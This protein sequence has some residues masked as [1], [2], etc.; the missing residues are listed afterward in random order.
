MCPGLAGKK[1]FVA[2]ASGFI[3]SRL[4][5][6]LTRA[7]GAEVHAL[8][9]RVGTVG[10]ARLARLSGVR[11][12]YGDVR[13]GRRVEEAGRGCSYFVYCVTGSPG[14]SRRQKAEELTGTANVLS[15]A[16]REG[17]ER[18]VYFSSAAVHDP[19]RSGEE[20][21]EESPRNGK[22]LAWRKILGE[23]L[24]AEHRRREGTPTVVLRPTCVW[25][26]WSP[27]WTAAAAALIRKGV[28]FLRSAGGGTANPIYIDNL[29][30]AV[31]LAFTK[32]EAVGEAFLINDDEPRTWGELYGGYA[33]FL[34]VPLRSLP[35]ATGTLEGLR[36]SL[37]NARQ[38]L[39]GT[40]SG[41]AGSG[42]DVLRQLYDH[43]P[44]VR[45]GVSL[46]PERIQW[47][48]RAYAARR[49]GAEKGPLPSADFLPADP[50]SRPMRE[51]YRAKARYSNAKAKR[52]LG[53]RPRVSFQAALDVTCQWL[54]YAGYR[55][56]G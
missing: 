4:A 54:E 40:L 27:T 7:Y 47:L 35:E 25:G 3:G 6:C 49:G 34:G 33:R 23:A 37:H 56:P 46:L 17:A 14:S 2:G 48:L 45:V 43:V 52:V 30:D 1:I 26:P 53:W 11:I 19:V 13:D 9:R 36:I 24:V 15:A 31:Y 39:Q 5:E 18:A 12:F 8:V 22:V 20:I 16:A 21:R 50:F 41:R 10:A 42:S 29:V 28:P 55:N 51:L 38:I 32:P 44:A